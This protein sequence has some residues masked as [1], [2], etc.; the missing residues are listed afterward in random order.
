MHQINGSFI[1]QDCTVIV[2]MMPQDRTGGRER[3]R[4]RFINIPS[5]II[6]ILS[7]YNNK[8]FQ[9]LKHLVCQ[10]E[11]RPSASLWFIKGPLLWLR[12]LLC[13]FPFQPLKPTYTH[14]PSKH[15]LL[16]YSCPWVGNGRMN[17]TTTH[18]CTYIHV[19]VMQLKATRTGSHFKV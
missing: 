4:E 18:A 5:I 16:H 3:E 1:Y 11:R 12:A 10:T 2:L 6:L 8:S 7:L 15:T 19:S 13:N 9:A 17:C 14:P